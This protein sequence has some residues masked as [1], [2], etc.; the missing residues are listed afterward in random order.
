MDAPGTP[1]PPAPPAP[2]APRVG[3]HVSCFGTTHLLAALSGVSQ[4]GFHGLEVYADTTHI[5]A[6]RPA[7]FR[8]IMD[9]AGVRL[10][11]VHGGGLLT[12]EEF[13]AGEIAEW[14]R[15]LRWVA[16]AGGDYAVF[17]GGESHVDDATDV[18]RAASFLNEVGKTAVAAGVRLC[19]EPNLTC[20]FRNGE[21]IADLMDR[22][23]PKR[24]WL[25]A[26]TAHLVSMGVDPAMFLVTQ[27]QRLAVLHVRDLRAADD[28]LAATQPR[29]E[30]GAGIVDLPSVADALR[31]VGFDGWIV[32]AVD[33]P[34]SSPLES[35]RATA[36]HFRGPLGFP[37]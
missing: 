24:V 5:Y 11:G 13:R 26:D 19:Y 1:A 3:F 28:P 22:T 33:S 12:S 35:V 6:D 32:G 37:F 31:A 15:L 27:R 25:S 2:R 16:D 18:R 30:P 9:I 23:D 10:A 17:Y 14:Q 4:Q 36:A 20:P 29:V 34:S 7:E 8:A 21:R